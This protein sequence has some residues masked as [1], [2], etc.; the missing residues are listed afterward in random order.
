LVSPASKGPG[1]FVFPANPAAASSRPADIS[2]TRGV[3]DT[4]SGAVMGG[5][6]ETAI[7][8]SNLGEAGPSSGRVNQCSGTG[9]NPSKPSRHLRWCRA[10]EPPSRNVLRFIRASSRVTLFWK[11]DPGFSSLPRLERPGPRASQWRGSP[12]SFSRPS[13]RRFQAARAWCES[14]GGSPTPA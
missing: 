3:T 14:G 10:G 6:M 7:S 2:V 4:E 8:Q 13:A 1:R 11:F 9:A 12:S 5:L